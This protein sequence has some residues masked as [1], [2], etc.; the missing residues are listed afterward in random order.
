MERSRAEGSN[1]FKQR[2]GTKR[3]QDMLRLLEHRA[4]CEKVIDEASRMGWLNG[5][6]FEHEA[7]DAGLFP[8]CW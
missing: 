1:I 6:G 5:E 2:K 3:A 4:T 7:K 8:R